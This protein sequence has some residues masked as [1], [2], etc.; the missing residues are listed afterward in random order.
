MLRARPVDRRHHC[1][2]PGPRDEHLCVIEDG[3]DEEN[4]EL[5]KQIAELQSKLEGR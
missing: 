5:K 2:L 1:G 3:V 4:E